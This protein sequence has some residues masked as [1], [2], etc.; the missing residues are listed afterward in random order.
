[1][2]RPVIADLRS[3]LQTQYVDTADRIPSGFALVCGLGGWACVIGT[4]SYAIE[5]E[6]RHAAVALIAGG[7]A[8]AAGMAIAL[9]GW[10][11]SRTPRIVGIVGLVANG[12]VLVAV[13]TL[14][15]VVR[16]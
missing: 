2:N 14:A 15:L 1:M 16:W 7:A 6:T 10:R 12:V 4:I 8:S 11:T 3:G 13:I 9:L 5:N